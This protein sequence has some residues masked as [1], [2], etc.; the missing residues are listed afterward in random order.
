MLFCSGVGV[1]GTKGTP[2]WLVALPVMQNPDADQDH[3]GCCALKIAHAVVVTIM[4]SREG[5]ALS[6]FIP[7]TSLFDSIASEGAVWP[8][9]EVRAC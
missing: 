2:T 4:G 9:F 7:D 6:D 1:Y 8:I 3:V 5:L